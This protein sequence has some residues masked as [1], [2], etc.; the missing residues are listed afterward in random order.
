MTIILLWNA[1]VGIK[2]KSVLK[3]FS[4]WAVVCRKMVC[5][6][7]SVLRVAYLRHIHSSHAYRKHMTV[8][9]SENVVINDNPQDIKTL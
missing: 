1:A 5:H 6:Y 7:P 4:P 3:S 2:G 9:C 8:L